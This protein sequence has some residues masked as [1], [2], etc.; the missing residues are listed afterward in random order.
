MASRDEEDRGAAMNGKNFHSVL[1]IH[2]VAGFY[3][4]WRLLAMGS[5]A[6]YGNPHRSRKLG[7]FGGETQRQGV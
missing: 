4:Q 5:V 2:L 6:V 7:T 1:L 3:H